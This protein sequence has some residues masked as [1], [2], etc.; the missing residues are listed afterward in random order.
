[1]PQHAKTI[2]GFSAHESVTFAGENECDKA[3]M[4]SVMMVAA[5]ATHLRKLASCCM[6]A[7]H[8]QALLDAN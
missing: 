2:R 6:N 5:D 8:Y 1:M 3:G 7:Q 4:A